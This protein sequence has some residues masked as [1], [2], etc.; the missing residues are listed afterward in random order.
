MGWMLS[1][2]T[3][4]RTDAARTGDCERKVPRTI[5]T[6]LKH[7]CIIGPKKKKS[8]R[9]GA[10][11]VGRQAG[12]LKLKLLYLPGASNMRQPLKILPH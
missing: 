6:S 9:W 4:K 3:Q 1:V 2:S 12:N 5:T 11:A 8:Q 7:K 10:L